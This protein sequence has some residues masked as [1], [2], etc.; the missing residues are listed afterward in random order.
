ESKVARPISST[1]PI[2]TALKWAI[3][4][5]IR[6]GMSPASPITP[7]SA[8]ARTWTTRLPAAVVMTGLS[9][10][11]R[12]VA[13]R[14]RV[15]ALD[16]DVLELERVQRGHRGVQ[17]QR[18]QR[19]WLAGQLEPGLVEVVEVEVS[20]AEG[21]HEVADPQAGDLGDH[22]R[23]QRVGGDVERHAEEHV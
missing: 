20:V 19:P 11:E 6:Q 23:E 2:V 8:T 4:P 14:G 17:A 21:V 9:S 18:G 10:G 12:G 1:W 13:Q 22:V 7:F 15:G 5:G 3:S 16:R